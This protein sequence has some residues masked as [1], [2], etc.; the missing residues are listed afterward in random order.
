MIPAAL[1]AWAARWNVPPQAFA[2][3]RA[4]TAAASHDPEGKRGEAWAQSAV[5]LEA[6]QRGYLVWRNNVGALQ[7]AGGRWVRFGLANDSPALNAKIKSS[8][9]IGL[10]PVTITPQHVGRVIG[11]FWSREIKAPGWKFTGDAHETAQ[12]A[13]NTLI[14]SHGGDAGFTTGP[15]SL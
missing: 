4:I 11:Q 9:L 12:E 7:D 1:A 2:E 14:V 3:L 8:D 6:A 15:G 5:R 13:W 10:R